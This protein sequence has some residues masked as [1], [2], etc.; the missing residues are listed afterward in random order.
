[1]PLALRVPRLS[2]QDT[3]CLINAALQHHLEQ[4]QL[5]TCCWLWNVWLSKPTTALGLS[6]KRACHCL[7]NVAS[8]RK[9]MRSLPSSAT[10]CGSAWVLEAASSTLTA[11]V[12]AQAIPVQ[13]STPEA[14]SSCQDLSGPTLP[15][16]NCSPMPPFNTLVGQT[17]GSAIP[18]HG[19]LFNWHPRT[20]GIVLL[21]RFAPH[22]C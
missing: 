6:E 19:C 1:M 22:C 20:C 17:S 11:L 10:R 4:S 12:V 14:T 15:N 16:E 5:L 9:S 18:Q 3:L 8:L 13:L 7:P 2:E 21:E